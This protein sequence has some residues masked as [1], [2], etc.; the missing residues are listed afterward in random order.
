MTQSKSANKFLTLERMALIAIFAALICVCAWIAVPSPFNPAVPFTLQ[1]LAIILA[2]LIL[3]PLEALFTSIVYFMLGIVGLPVFSG[4]STF[5][6]KVFTASGGYLIGFFITPFIIALIRTAI[7]KGLDKKNISGAKNKT[8]HFVVYILL[9]VI[10]GI[11]AVDIPGVIVG[12]IIT[13]GSWSV[14]LVGFAFSFMPT[15][16]LKCV[17]AAVLATALEKPLDTI[18]KRKK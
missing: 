10:V 7:F 3:S 16:I 5:Y 11:L 8:I 9:A 12:K 18:R 14:T 2:G 17:A 13:N 6:S 15:D 1:T 4:F